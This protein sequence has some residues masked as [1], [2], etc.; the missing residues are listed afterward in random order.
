MS[1][2][3]QRRGSDYRR[4]RKCFHANQYTRKVSDTLDVDCISAS[5]KKLCKE[6]YLDKE[7]RNSN[8]SNGYRMI[9]IDILLS[10]LSKYLICSNCNTKAVLKEKIF[11]VCVCVCVDLP[12][13]VSHK[14]YERILRKINLASREVADDSMKNAA[15][16]VSA[17][18]SNEICVSGDGTWKTRGHTSRIGVCSVIGDVTGKGI[19]V[20][21]LSLYCKGCEKWRGPKSGHSY[22]EWKLKHQP[23]CVKNHIGSSSKM[24][25]D[26]M[27][28]IFQRSVPQR[29]AKYIKY[30]GDGDTKTFPELQRTAPY[31]IKNVECVGHI[32]KRMGA[33][34]RKL[35]TM[36]RGKKLSDGKSIS[37]KNRLTDKFIDTITTYYGNA[38][39]QNNS[40]VSD[41]SQAIWAIYSHYRSTDEE[42]MPHFCPI[43]DTSWCKYQKAVATNSASLFKHRNIVPIAIMDEIKPIIAELSAPKLLKKCVGGKT[44]NANESFNSTVWK[45]CPQTSVWV[46]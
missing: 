42:P 17:S 10:E 11:N 35:K 36:N 40:S 33:K 46:I 34:L 31:S 15:K 25:V 13:P 29:N 22:E 6:N 20:S 38:I 18:G 2:K 5:A 30:I 8:Q 3:A 28:E 12:P 14:S 1:S 41:M 24:E 27:K 7:V 23:H 44:Q 37:G 26:G 43:G 45:Y 32:Q 21:V 9:N 39:R 4:K 16:E 19:D